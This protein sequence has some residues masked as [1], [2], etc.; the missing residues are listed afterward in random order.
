[1]EVRKEVKRLSGRILIDMRENSRFIGFEYMNKKDLFEIKLGEK[2]D[3]SHLIRIALDFCIRF[4][5]DNIQLIN[6]DL[7][8]TTGCFDEG[9]II[10]LINE[11]LEEFDKFENGLII[12]DTDNIVGVN[13]SASSSNEDSANYSVQNQ[14]LWQNIL[15]FYNTLFNTN[16]TVK[17]CFIISSSPFLIKQLKSLT[18]FPKSK[19]EI[20]TEQKEIDEKSVKRKCKN[21]SNNYFEA[22]NNIDSCSYHDGALVKIDKQDIPI[23][24]E[25]MIELMRDFTNIEE[26]ASFVKNFVYLCCMRPLQESQETG[27]KRNKHND[28]ELLTFDPSVVQQHSEELKKQEPYLENYLGDEFKFYQDEL[29]YRWLE[30]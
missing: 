14:R 28:R 20:E 12:F 27:C 25:A 9:A 2:N 18:H 11:S 6:N 17:W 30:Q 5:I 22:Q 1:M 29:N 19:F 13:E 23:T 24:R 15:H 8:S 3:S 21:C 4:K 7:I 10:E 16:G 26:L